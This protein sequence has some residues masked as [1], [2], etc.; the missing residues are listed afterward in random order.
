MHEEPRADGEYPVLELS[1]LLG[2]CAVLVGLITAAIALI[3]PSSSS[4]A[5]TW[6]VTGALVLAAYKLTSVGVQGAWEDG[7]RGKAFA[8]AS[9][10]LVCLFLVSQTVTWKD[11]GLSIDPSGTAGDSSATFAEPAEDDAD[12]DYVPD[13]ADANPVDPTIQVSEDYH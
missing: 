3:N 12:G 7:A 8:M 13:D 2:F 4:G 11:I 5:L 10:G 9:V 6:L 1:G